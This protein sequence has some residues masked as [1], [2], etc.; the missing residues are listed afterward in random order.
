MIFLKKDNINID[1][2]NTI[3]KT[4]EMGI[5]GINDI[6]DKVKKAD[7]REFLIAQRKEYENIV[8]KVTKLF[9][10]FGLEEKELNNFVK[11]NSKIM[12]EM[13]LIKDNSDEM[14]AKMMMEGTNKGVIK[15]NKALNENNNADNEVIDLAKELLELMEHNFNK[16]KVYL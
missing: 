7:F 16:L 10:S 14:I 6:I 1:F 2:L 5:V 9:T 11:M 13:K 15:I 8:K 3:Y 12:S 4:S